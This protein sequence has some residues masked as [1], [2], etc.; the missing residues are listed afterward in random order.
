MRANIPIPEYNLEEFRDDLKDQG[1]YACQIKKSLPKYI[2]KPVPARLLWLPVHLLIIAISSYFIYFSAYWFVQLPLAMLV[3]HSLAV[4]FML[5]HEI[6]HGS[7]V[8]NKTLIVFLSNV[9]FASFGLHAK[10][11]IAFHN[12]KHHHLTQH[13][14]RD[15][16]CFGKQCTKNKML[17]KIQKTLPGSKSFIS[18]TFLFW[19]FSFYT[20]YNVWFQKRIFVNR[21]EKKISRI[22]S[23]LCYCTWIALAT[24][25]HPHGLLYFFFVPFITSNFVVLSYLSTN[26]FLSPLTE[27]VNDPLVNSLTVDTSRFLR[28]IHLNFNY[29]VEHHIFPY[30]NPT[31]APMVA[32]VLKEKFAK[33]Y[34]HIKHNAALKLLYQRPKFYYDDVTLIN[35]RTQEKYPTIIFDD[36]I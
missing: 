34:N 26:H 36:F 14:Y 25:I 10:A 4:I 24:Y 22:Y 1:Y 15:P 8:K 7:V 16:D 23:V 28:F 5:G 18:Y 9:C 17:L 30:V 3:G 33:K 35:P 11:F 27:E 6:A 2:F 31:Y 21:R 13:P 12:R 19:F 20:F 32:E 29:H